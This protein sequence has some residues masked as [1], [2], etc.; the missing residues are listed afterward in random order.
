M[1]SWR[2]VSGVNHVMLYTTVIPLEI[3]VVLT[4]LT[5]HPLLRTSRNIVKMSRTPYNARYFDGNGI[6]FAVTIS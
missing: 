2:R 1:K 6:W 4:I 3:F 5:L